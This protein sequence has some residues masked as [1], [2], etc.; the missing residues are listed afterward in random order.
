MAIGAGATRL[1]KADIAAH[2]GGD[3]DR[4]AVRFQERSLLAM[5]LEK[6]RD[7]IGIERRRGGPVRSRISEVLDVMAERSPAIGS[8]EIADLVQR[9]QTEHEPTAEIGGAE[10]GTFLAPQGDDPKGQ[11]PTALIGI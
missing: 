11:V 1:G 5:E 4:N 8:D 6:G 2:R 3:A 10:P 9:R 7:E